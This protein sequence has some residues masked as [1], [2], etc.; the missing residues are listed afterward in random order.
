MT[1]LDILLR[2]LAAA[3]MGVLIGTEREIHG[4][5]AGL[6]TH[7]LV[8]IGSA[9]FMITSIG[10][11]ERYM[12]MGNVDPSRIASG[13]V[14]GIGFLGAGAIIRYGTSIKGLTTAASI[15]TVSAIGLAA[16]AGMYVAGGITTA[17]ALLVLIL[18][19]LEELAALKR[20]SKKIVAVVSDDGETSAEDIKNIIE[21]YGGRTKRTGSD[22]NEKEKTIT[23][24]FFVILPKAYRKD[25]IVEIECLSGV[26]SVAWAQTAE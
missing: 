23:L 26:K 1:E 6:R 12:T 4:C 13:V 19:R 22:K 25:V 16:G 24:E 3:A 7:I 15:W 21:A 17:V 11:A 5:A 20:Q 2:I 10:M 9:L 18:S 8:C 14:T